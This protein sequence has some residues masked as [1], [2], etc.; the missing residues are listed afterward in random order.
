VV[1]GKRLKKSWKKEG[2]KV[3]VALNQLELATETYQANQTD[4]LVDCTDIS[5]C[6]PRRYPSTDGLCTSPECTTHTLQVVIP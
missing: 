5:A 3:A 1:P 2:G 6:D 4:T